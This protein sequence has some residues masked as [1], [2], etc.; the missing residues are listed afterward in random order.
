MR[1]QGSRNQA[2]PRQ[3]TRHTGSRHRIQSTD[4][5]HTDKPREASKSTNKGKNKAERKH[6]TL[7]WTAASATGV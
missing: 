6:L 2:A 4:H 1:S 7:N 3:E 5:R